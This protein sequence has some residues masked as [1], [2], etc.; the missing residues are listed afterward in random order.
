MSNLGQNVYMDIQPSNIVSTGKVSYRNGNPVVQFIIGENDIHLMGSSVRF[1]GNIQFFRDT[2][3]TL[4]TEADTNLLCIDPKLGIY[5]IIDTLT[6]SS[7]VHKSTI[8]SIRFYNRF[9]ATYLPLISSQEEALSYMNAT[10]LQAPNTDLQRLEVV[11]NANDDLYAGSSFC[12][13]L[14]C[15]LFNGRNPIPLSRANG[16]GGIL[17]EINLAP[18]ANVMFS[19]TESL[20]GLTDAWYE[21]TNLKLIAEGTVVSPGTSVGNTFE[22][23]SIH[24]YFNSVNSTNT[25]LNF[26]LGLGSVLSVWANFL[27]AKF[28]NSFARNGMLTAPLLNDGDT[29]AVIKDVVF[30]RAGIQEPLQYTL[31]TNIKDTTT[32]SAQ[33]PQLMKNFVNA[34]KSWYGLQHTQISPAQTT[35]DL[36]TLIGDIPGSGMIAG[37]GVSYDSI[38]GLGTSFQNANFGLNMTTGLATDNPN[39]VFLFARNKS[40]LVFTPNGVQVM[41]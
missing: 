34:V 14:P 36:G 11:N 29:L 33:D 25:I 20:T 3:K 22:Y 1:C 38:S 10:T 2:A 24:S 9:M 15:G 35:R 32:T 41:N 28:I 26:Q 5:S 23:N 8:E 19:K 40:T 7:Q 21:L 31:D 39:G 30:T 12:V 27:P 4:Q 16:V 17:V 6:L 13:S 37:V 18:D